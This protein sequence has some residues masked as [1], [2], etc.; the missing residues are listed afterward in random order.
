[1]P[2]WAAACSRS[3]TAAKQRSGYGART[4]N[5]I[6][7]ESAIKAK[8]VAIFRRYNADMQKAGRPYRYG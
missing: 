7:A 1:M 3:A 8:V 4:S 2:D 6:A 5:E